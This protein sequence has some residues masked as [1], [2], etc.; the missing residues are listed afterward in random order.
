MA[1]RPLTKLAEATQMPV[2]T[3][4]PAAAI[5]FCAPPVGVIDMEL[6]YV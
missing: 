3:F 6:R 4:E 2:F 1:A 5:T